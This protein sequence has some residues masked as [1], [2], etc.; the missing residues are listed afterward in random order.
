MTM[1]V[2]IPVHNQAPRLRLTLTAL[3]CQEEIAASD[4]EVIVVN[5]DSSD[6]VVGVLESARRRVPYLLRSVECK[7]GGAR[8]IPRN[9]GAHVANGDLILFID[10]DALPGRRLLA[11]HRDG[12]PTCG[13]HL[14]LGDI[15]VLRETEFVSDPAE[16]TS[17]ADRQPRNRLILPLDSV[18]QGIRDEQLMLHAEKG[19]YP[20]HSRWHHQLEE[21]LKEGTVPFAWTGVIPHNLSLSRETLLRIGSFDV[22]LPHMEGWDFGIRALRAGCIFGFAK[23]ARS[24]HL[25]H[26]REVGDMVRNNEEAQ[27]ILMRR[28]PDALTDLVQLWFHAALGDPYLPAELNLGNWRIVREIAADPERLAECQRLYRLWRR[29]REPV[30]VLEYWI[31]GALNSMFSSRRVLH[32]QQIEA[33]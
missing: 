6:D 25:F 31:G 23:G 2:V 16:G 33:N 17:H 27:T 29:L 19:G 9:K 21:V 3:E 18:R 5:D 24:F 10:A 13:S 12:H 15:Y 1:S 14:C 28:Y 30:S 22:S 7:S 26:R 20:G 32:T 11:N 4:Y 8:G